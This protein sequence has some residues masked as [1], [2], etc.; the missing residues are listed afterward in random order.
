MTVHASYSVEAIS[1]LHALVDA[2]KKLV[3]IEIEKAKAE[4][5]AE[6]NRRGDLQALWDSA[7]RPELMSISL[8]EWDVDTRREAYPDSPVTR[9]LVDPAKTFLAPSSGH[10]YDVL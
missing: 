7:E 9:V 8:D 3:L 2:V 5:I 1:L 4:L 10:L 6:L